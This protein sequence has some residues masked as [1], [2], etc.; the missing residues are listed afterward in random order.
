MKNNIEN[1]DNNNKR[2]LTRAAA[3]LAASLSAVTLSHT[4]DAQTSLD[5]GHSITVAPSDDHL[6][7]GPIK[8]EDV[9]RV[10]ERL[11]TISQLLGVTFG[12]STL[13]GLKASSETDRTVAQA[14]I[15]TTILMNFNAILKKWKK[16]RGVDE[17][18]NSSDAANIEAD[19]RRIHE[20]FG[21]LQGMPISKQM[22]ELLGQKL[23]NV[24]K[25]RAEIL[26][27]RET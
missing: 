21:L 5:K 25:L 24:R 27:E 1:P 6:L 23:N 14:G 16:M 4:A 13:D 22:L 18:V 7:A 26:L 12:A 2:Q 19:S 20:A 10:R 3:L 9:P 11:N 8:E 15:T 17:R